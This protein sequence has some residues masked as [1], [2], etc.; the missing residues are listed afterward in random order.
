MTHGKSKLGHT[1]EPM[2]ASLC[3]QYQQSYKLTQVYNS[4]GQTSYDGNQ[5]LWFKGPW[6]RLKDRIFETEC[7][8]ESFL[9]WGSHRNSKPRTPYTWQ[10]GR[11]AGEDKDEGMYE[12]GCPITQAHH[13]WQVTPLLTTHMFLLLGRTYQPEHI[14]HKLILPSWKDHLGTDCGLPEDSWLPE[15]SIT[16]TNSTIR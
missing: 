13:L 12:P 4:H 2:S 6:R 3:L 1:Q 9:S 11:K 16:V 7:I 14:G 15:W 10:G 8:L 5:L